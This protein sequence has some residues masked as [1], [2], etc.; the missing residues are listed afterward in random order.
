ME[1][2]GDY[3]DEDFERWEGELGVVSVEEIEIEDAPEMDVPGGG[4]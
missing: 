1:D 2:V 4:C 3:L